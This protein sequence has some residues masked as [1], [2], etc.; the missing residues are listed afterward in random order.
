MRHE[1]KK[2][3]VGNR[4][5]LAAAVD[6]DLVEPG[7]GAAKCRDVLDDLADA[8]GAFVRLLALQSAAGDE[9]PAREVR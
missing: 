2:K 6:I 4:T 8:L 5:E 3:A 7:A 9:P 1:G